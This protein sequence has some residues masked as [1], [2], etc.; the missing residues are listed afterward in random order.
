MFLQR[1]QRQAFMLSLM[2]RTPT[3]SENPIT[4]VGLDPGLANLGL[5]A[6]REAGKDAVYLDSALIRTSSKQAQDERLEHL[7][8][9]VGDFLDS[10]HPHALAIE[11]QYF[12]QRGDIAFKVG[13]AVGVCL[14]AAKHHGVDVVSYGPM[15]VKQA[16]VGLGKASKAQVA[17]M[18]RALLHLKKMPDSSHAADAL[19][20]A[21]THISS[22]RIGAL[23]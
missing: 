6:V 13:Q 9:A 11:D 22:R 23:G 12:H 15:Q 10:H 18:V 19:A 20:L 2:P 7:Y 17:Y 14:L 4:V 8:H 5:G 21:L 16:L 1:R 3:A